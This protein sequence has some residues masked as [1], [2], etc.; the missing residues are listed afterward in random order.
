[1]RHHLTTFALGPVLLAQGMRVRRITPRLP[2]P[3]GPRSGTAGRGSPLRLLIAGDS[4][5]AGVGA[6]SQEQALSGAVVQALKD[7][8]RVSWQVDAKTGLRT[9]G[10]LARLEA[11]APRRFDV[12]LLSVGVNDITGFTGTAAWLTQLADLVNLLKTRFSARHILLTNL[13]PMHLFP[14]L[15]Q[16]LRWYLGARAEQLNMLLRVFVDADDACELVS[17]E[18]PVELDC[19]AIDGFHPGP[20]AYS[21]WGQAAAQIIR[22]RLVRTRCAS[23][24][25]DSRP[26]SY[27]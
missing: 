8:F 1:L 21:V 13:P 4:A 17:P 14:A 3:P 18:M 10:V 26:A 24:D 15:P 19:M 11:L 9:L 2:E 25:G 27:P 22:D 6:E 20:I 7:Q 23:R 12:A 16:P 5:A